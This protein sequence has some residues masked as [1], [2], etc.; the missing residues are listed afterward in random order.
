MKKSRWSVSRVLS[1]PD[2]AEAKICGD[3]HS[4]GISV[5]RYLVATYPDDNAKTR[6]QA[7]PDTVPIR[8]CSRWGLP[9]PICYQ[10]GGA[11]LPH[12]FTLT[13]RT[14]GLFS[15]ALSLRSPSPDVIR[16]R[17]SVEPGLSSARLVSRAEPR[18]SDHLLLS[19]M[20][21]WHKNQC[22]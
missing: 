1:S 6:L 9:C 15:V 21:C 18:S 20:G 3:D 5:T 17:V 11:L 4:S 16:H 12:P 22:L 7:E 19:S 10:I 13:G 8:F 14:G 2:Y